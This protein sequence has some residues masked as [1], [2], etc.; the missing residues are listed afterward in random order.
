MM[1]DV[2]LPR[3]VSPNRLLPSSDTTGE[4]EPGRPKAP[5]RIEG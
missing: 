4:E 3:E 1:Q 2:A 5:A